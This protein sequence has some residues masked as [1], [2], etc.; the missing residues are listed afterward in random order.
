MASTHVYPQMYTHTHTPVPAIIGPQWLRKSS[1]GGPHKLIVVR[2]W[3]T[4]VQGSSFSSSLTLVQAPLRLQFS[5][6]ETAAVRASFGD[7][8]PE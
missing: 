7:K 1:E 5:H 4:Q 3:G 2:S 6:L 8:D